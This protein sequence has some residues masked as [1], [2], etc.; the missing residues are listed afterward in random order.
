MNQHIHIIRASKSSKRKKKR[1]MRGH[2]ETCSFSLLHFKLTFALLKQLK[3]LK[4]TECI[5]NAHCRSLDQSL[6]VLWEKMP[7]VYANIKISI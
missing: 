1:V 3:P 2:V 6:N 7:I 4:R 5:N